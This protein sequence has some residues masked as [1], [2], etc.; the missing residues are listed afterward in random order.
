M[1]KSPTLVIFLLFF[2]C[3]ASSQTFKAGAFVGLTASQING[4]DSAGFNKPGLEGGLKI[5][6][7]LKEKM[8]LSLEIQYSQRG[9]K[10]ASNIDGTPQ[11]TY[12][13]DYVSVPIIIS[14]K[15]WESEDY[16]RLHFHGG[17]SYGRLVNAELDNGGIDNSRFIDLWRENDLSI[18]G[19]ATYFVYKNFGLTVRYNRSL[20]RLYRNTQENI[21][22]GGAIDSLSAFNLSFHALYMF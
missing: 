8:D 10:E 6:V 13:T 2:S 11:V 18:L 4:D 22:N 1:F 12:K 19:G 5:S 16:F 3:V 15:D 17:L 14:L 9:A 21:D 20:I 7:N